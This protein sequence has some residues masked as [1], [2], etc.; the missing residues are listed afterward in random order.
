M[1]FVQQ[2]L[3]G[4]AGIID[5]FTREPRSSRN[6]RELQL[7]LTYSRVK[8]VREERQGAAG[9]IDLFAGELSP[10]GT[11]GDT[12]L[13]TYSPVNFVQQEL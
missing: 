13:L 9:I 6:C 4:T 7:L 10:T 2:E 8:F 1:N 12:V 5:L 11:A 3:L